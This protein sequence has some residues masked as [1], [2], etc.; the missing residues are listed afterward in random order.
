MLHD[1]HL[2][3]LGRN[4]SWKEAKRKRFQLAKNVLEK[5]SNKMRHNHSL[6]HLIYNRVRSKKPNSKCLRSSF[7]W[8]SFRP[9]KLISFRDR[10]SNKNDS[11]FFIFARG[12][13][14]KIRKQHAWP[15][16]M[17]CWNLNIFFRS[18]A[19]LRACMENKKPPKREEEKKNIPRSPF[20]KQLFT[21]FRIWLD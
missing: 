20:G 7:S 16:L 13:K 6:T 10:S 1:Y 11:R 12:G 18:P 9:T 5:K 4:S 2:Q 21:H 19:R 15:I 3:W 14:V 8:Y 17:I